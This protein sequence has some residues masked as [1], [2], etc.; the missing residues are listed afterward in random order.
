MSI[1]N[2]AFKEIIYKIV[3]YGP[4]LGGKTTNLQWIHSSIP[5]SNRGELISLAT[6]ADRT[7]FF[8][9]M[10][11][12]IGTIKGF[13]VKFQLYTVPGQIYYNAIRKLV[14]RGADGVIFVADSQRERLDD[15]IESLENLKN[16]LSDYGYSLEDIA[17]VLQYN[18]QDL[19][20]LSTI[21]ELQEALNP[22]NSPYYTSIA[23]HG[24]GVKKTLKGIISLMIKNIPYEDERSIIHTGTTAPLAASEGYSSKG[25]SKTGTL[26]SRAAAAN[27]ITKELPKKVRVAAPATST[28]SDE[29]LEEVS[30]TLSKGTQKIGFQKTQHTPSSIIPYEI[31]QKCDIFFKGI[32]VGA[33]ALTL[34]TRTNIDYKGFF[35][36]SGTVSYLVFFRKYWIKMLEFKN[37]VNK[38]INNVSVPFFKFNEIVSEILE[39]KAVINTLILKNSFDKVFYI[40]FNTLLGEM[41]ICPKGRNEIENSDINQQ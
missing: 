21:E 41:T 28:S 13:K 29:S 34:S 31:K 14:L 12:D 15:N 33:A 40:T 20:D 17:Y 5:P 32:K 8:D 39:E 19:D 10:P 11:L 16:N 1:V 18:K 3:Y 38:K 7:L 36:I 22:G 37:E 2:Y 26:L 23:I 4:A 24:D 35:Q 9:Y 27:K 6:Q 30:E 25:E